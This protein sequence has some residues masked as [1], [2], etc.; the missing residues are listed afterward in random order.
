MTQANPSAPA[1]SAA[2]RAAL[3]DSPLIVTVAPNGAYKQ[4]AD[5][6]AVP[7][8]AAALAQEARACL[9]AGAAMMHMHVRDAQGRHS[10]D[11]QAYRDALAAVRQAVGDSL[12]VQVTSEAAGVYKA[13]AQMAMVRELRPEAVSVG[14][15]EV[16]VPEI[17]EGELA[18]FFAWLAQERVMTQVI[19]YDAADVRRWHAL[20]ARG[21]VPAG[22]WSLLYVLGRYSAGQVSSPHDL[23]PF[24]QVAAESDDAL[25]WAICAFG[26][27]E[28]ACVTAAAAFDGH[29]RV[30][31]ENNLLL[32]DGSR[33]PGNAALVAQAVQGGLTLGR[34]IADAAD[35]RRIYGA[36][37]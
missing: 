18:A 22:A 33:A 6:P 1:Q 8:T 21:L 31:F 5:H 10:L 28:N 36:V 4:S 3:A 7:L 34:P 16:A 24:L 19:L 26:R 35:A 32:R 23:L 27:E 29:V 2:T 12:L 9:D 14:L 11:A 37:R 20:R 25:P 17:P 30:G 13:P 15:R